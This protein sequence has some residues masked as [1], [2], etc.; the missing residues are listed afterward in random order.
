MGSANTAQTAR[1]YPEACE[2]NA[3]RERKGR[4]YMKRAAFWGV[5][6]GLA[7]LLPTLYIGFQLLILLKVNSNGNFLIIVPII[8]GIGFYRWLYNKGVKMVLT[9]QQ[10]LVAIDTEHNTRE[11]AEIVRGNQ[12]AKS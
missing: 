3:R 5:I 12:T 11:I 2:W 10:M 4:E 8:V 1:R 9:A 6:S 7:A